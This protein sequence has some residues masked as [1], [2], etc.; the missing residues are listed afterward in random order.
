MG[1]NVVQMP[2]MGLISIAIYS[3]Y[4]LQTQIWIHKDLRK[5]NYELAVMVL[6][7]GLQIAV[8]VGITA[9]NMYVYFVD[10]P[11]L[12][13]GSRSNVLASQ[14]FHAELRNLWQPLSVIPMF[15]DAISIISLA[16]KKLLKSRILVWLLVFLILLDCLGVCIYQSI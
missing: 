5:G 15:I 12:S 1:Q 14:E 13:V 9:L 4:L 3:F 6:T 10:Q 2:Q 11:L 16:L 7:L 8:L